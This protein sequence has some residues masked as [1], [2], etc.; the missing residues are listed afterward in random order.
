VQIHTARSYQEVTL[1]LKEI[2]ENFAQYES[3]KK[4]S[5]DSTLLSALTSRDD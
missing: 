5:A 1:S 3:V 4:W 2:T